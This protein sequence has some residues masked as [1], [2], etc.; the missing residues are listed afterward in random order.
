MNEVGIIV[1]T[2]GNRP[3][4]LLQCL[5]SIRKSG[6]AHICLVATAGFSTEQYFLSG[7]IDQAE[8]DLGDGLAAAINQGVRALPAHL[9]YFSW[10][11]DD[12]L[13]LQDSLVTASAIL[14]KEPDT[15][16]VYG[17]CDYI[18]KSGTTLWTNRSGSWASRLLSFGPDMIPQPGCL[19]RRQSFDSVGGLQTGYKFAFDFDLFIRL[20]KV[21]KLRFADKVL[22]QFRWHPDSLTVKQRVNSAS[23]ASSV[24]VSHLPRGLRSI[25]EFWEYPVRRA[26]ILA[27]ARL[28]SMANRVA[29]LRS[30]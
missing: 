22:A 17:S 26:T 3:E 5:R 7:L 16:M 28:N 24:R 6:E 11:G 15:A 8:E 4:L 10:L 13:L 14:E 9:K 27:G 18:D 19:I 30:M 12:D 25:S 20:K 23:E 1:P 21:G 29:K 2:V